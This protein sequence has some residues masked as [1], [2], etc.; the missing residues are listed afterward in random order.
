[1][2][3]THLADLSLHLP[4]PIDRVSTGTAFNDAERAQ[5]SALGEAVER[6]CGNFVPSTLRRAAYSKA[7]QDAL[8][9]S[10]FALYSQNQYAETG[11]P[12]LPFTH[13][14]PVLWAQGTCLRDS[15][16][17]SIPASLVYLNYHSGPRQMEPITNFV[18]LAGIAA[19]QTPRAALTASMEEI[20]ERDATV[21]WWANRLPTRPIDPADP[22]LAGALIP[23]PE[24]GTGWA[25]GAGASRICRYRL[26]SIPTVF[27]VTVSGVLLE[28][29]DNR[30]LMMGF[31]ARPD[32]ATAVLKALAEAVTL[33]YY[34]LGLLNPDGDIWVAAREGVIPIDFYK[35]FRS[36]RRYIDA[37]RADFRDVADLGCH[38]QIWLDPRMRRYLEPVLGVGDPITLDQLPRITGDPFDAYLERFNGQGIEAYGVDVTTPDVAEAGLSVARVIAPGTYSNAPAAFPLLGG[39]RLYTDPVKL[40]LRDRPIREEDVNVAPLPHT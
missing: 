38:S 13:D 39:S 27:D 30:I 3:S 26:L 2:W 33:R 19:G 5:Q 37:Y 34:A 22:Q 29:T 23:A 14:L 25:Y 7:G 35:P 6:Y 4:W 28:D 18:M 36:D 40:G 21:I 12:F 1:M 20:I 8:A 11:C 17:A 24:L 16:D 10:T 9:P 15:S 32:P 31:A